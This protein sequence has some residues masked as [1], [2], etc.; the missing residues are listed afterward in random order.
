MVF[1]G[2][3]PVDAADFDELRG[4]MGKLR[5]NDASFHFQM[6][7]SAAGMQGAA[8]SM[9]GLPGLLQSAIESGGM[10]V[11]SRSAASTAT[12]AMHCTSVDMR[13]D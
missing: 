13:I 6:E 5:L 1:C 3:F 11:G 9:G 12:S 10:T 8:D 4:A 7:S 2:L